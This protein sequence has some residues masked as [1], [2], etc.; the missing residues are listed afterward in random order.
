MKIVAFVPAKG[1][2]ERIENKN[3]KLLDG[4][5]LFLST[6]EK[7]VNCGFIDEVYLDTESDEIINLAQEAGCKVLKRD[8]KLA[9]NKTDGNL[10]FMN[11]V[12]QVDADVY[13]Q[14]L[15]T[16]P[17]IR[18]ET[19]KAGINKLKDSEH[20]SVVFVKRDKQYLWGS[21][22]S[23]PLYN[24]EKIPNSKDL[25]ETIIETM[26]LYII[27]KEAAVNTQRRIGNNPFLFE[28]SPLEAIDVNYPGDFD[29]A[30]LIA[31]GIRE[32][33]RKLFNNLAKLLTSSI[34]SDI[35]EDLG[36]YNQVIKG[37]SLNI[38]GQK[39]LGRAKTLKIKKREQT[40]RNSI[41]DALKTYDTIVP[42]DIIVVE[43]EMPEYAYFGELNANLA[44]RSGACAA[45]IGGNT[46]DNAEVSSLKFPVF[47]S[48][49]TCVDIKNR[50]T[51]AHMNKSIKINGVAVAFQQLLFADEEGIVVIPKRLEETVLK[52]S[53]EVIKKEKSIIADVALGNSIESIRATFGD[54]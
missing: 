41:Y 17:F 10:L 42:N 1:T 39:I 13:L 14:V 31:A 9:S 38:P 24:V 22:S 54:F 52:H 49:K 28:V 33:E 53:Y 23:K 36:M 40:D 2:S 11:Q 4:K 25:P 51:V 3:I 15:V 27:S 50:G 43:N 45:I 46:R 35:I 6:I 5:P 18:P 47:S 26:G 16:S 30:E 37:L 12:G 32:K 8:P 20:D 21:S 29:L 44:I 48:G 34:L 7:L 19:I